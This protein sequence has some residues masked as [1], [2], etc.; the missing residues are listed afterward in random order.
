MNAEKN[1]KVVS[2]KD[3]GRC[4]FHDELNLTGCE[5][6]INS[7][8]SGIS[9]PFVHSHKQN[10]EL[11]IVLEGAGIAYI[12]GDEFE[13][14]KGDILRLNPAAKRCF[15]ASK[16]KGIKFICIQT[17]ANSLE[18]FSMNDGVINDEKPSWL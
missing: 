17:K 6:S 5:M 14:K 15:S 8:P 10:E 13:I 2:L 1:Y 9:V 3:A 4:E 18:Q 16:D 12:D 7:L 11:Y